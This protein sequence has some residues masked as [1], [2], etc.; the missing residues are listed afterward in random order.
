MRYHGKHLDTLDCT[1][2]SCHKEDTE[3]SFGARCV[4]FY[5]SNTGR[6]VIVACREKDF[7]GERELC[8]IQYELYVSEG[9]YN[10]F[11][12][13]ALYNWVLGLTNILLLSQL[14]K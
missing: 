2:F 6:L 11:Y 5:F 14:F 13:L 8:D 12:H 3:Q 10:S 7:L 1:A 4:F 9:R